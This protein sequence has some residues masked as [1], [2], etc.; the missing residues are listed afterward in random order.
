M[1][2]DLQIAQQIGIDLV[3]W[4]R[5]GRSRTA[6]ECLYAHPLHQLPSML[7]AMLCLVRTPWR[8]NVFVERLWRTIN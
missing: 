4:L 7:M 5:L 8:D 2:R 3:T 6:I 1:R